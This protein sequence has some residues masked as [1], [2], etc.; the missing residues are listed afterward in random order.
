MN[1]IKPLNC[2][3]ARSGEDYAE[4]IKAFGAVGNGEAAV[5]STT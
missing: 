4:M 2:V 3:R 1:S 5:S